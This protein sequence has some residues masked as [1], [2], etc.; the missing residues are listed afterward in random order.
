M[1]E[2]QARSTLGT[3]WRTFGAALPTL[4]A[5]HALSRVSST[6]GRLVGALFA[7]AICA[8]AL[9]AQIRGR[10]PQSGGNS[11]WWFSGGAAATTSLTDINDGAS[12]AVW[13]FG[14]DPL[15]QMRGSLERSS[16]DFTTL[17][18]TAAYGRVDLLVTPLPGM[19]S[20]PAI[21]LPASC[22]TSCAA[23]VQ[24]WSLMGQFRSGGGTGF[25]TLFEATGGVTGFRDMRTSDSLSLAIGKPSGT[26]DLSGAIGAGFGYPISNGLVIALVQ[27]FGM[28]FHS[29]ADLPS[30]T[31]RTWRIRTTRASL[32]FSF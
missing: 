18:L 3:R 4:H 25:H 1:S 5:R 17:G 29:K 10:A 15:W 13:R 27:D 19:V 6:A 7:A 22:V 9:D 16:D 30:G 11:R 24:M 12:G 28:G 8:T 21:A 23:Q 26:M 32:R 31:S 2:P 20:A 14:S